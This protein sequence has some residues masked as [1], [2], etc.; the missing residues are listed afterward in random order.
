MVEIEN[1]NATSDT[2]MK[3]PMRSAREIGLRCTNRIAST[4]EQ[5]AQGIIAASVER[6]T[7]RS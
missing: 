7:T 6:F 5:N 2:G 1:T 4:T 3:G